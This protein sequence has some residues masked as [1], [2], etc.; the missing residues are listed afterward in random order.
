[1]RNFLRDV[2]PRRL[3]WA[4]AILTGLTWSV[5]SIAI[6]FALAF[7]DAVTLSWF[8]FAVA[9][10]VLAVALYGRSPGRLTEL[11]SLPWLIVVAGLA[12]AGN[13][14][15]FVLAIGQTS[16]SYATVAIQLGPL[17][18]AVL[19]VFALREPLSRAQ[20]QGLL[21]AFGGFA[22][23]AHDQIGRLSSAEL[24]RQGNLWLVF[25]ALTWVA[26]A[27]IQRRLTHQGWGAQKLN[28]AVFTICLLL[29]SPW[30]LPDSLIGLTL[31]QWAL[32]IFLALNTVVSYGA[33]AWALKL[34]PVHEVSLIISF[35][36]LVT[37]GLVWLLD[38]LRWFPFTPEPLGLIGALGA[39]IAISGIVRTLA[40]A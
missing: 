16:A 3:G 11:V 26:W 8:R 4:L 27:W 31:G 40:K 10:A 20:K 17:L 6:K 15:G 12:L 21:L 34:A 29:L 24:F 28:L 7:S 33:L 19:G 1:M 9:A 32:L 13:Y 23:F 30:A 2:D 35:Y 14:V 39:V 37:L 22:L 18:L 25:A 5:L 36:P 38:Q